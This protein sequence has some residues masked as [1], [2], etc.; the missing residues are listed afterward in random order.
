MDRSWSEIEIPANELLLEQ[1]EEWI[2]VHSEGHEKKSIFMIMPDCFRP[3][4]SMKK[5]SI[6]A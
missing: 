5:L 3:L 6:S 1:D 2:I 4:V